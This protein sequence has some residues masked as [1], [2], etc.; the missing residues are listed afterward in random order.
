VLTQDGALSRSLD[1]AAGWRYVTS[2][3]GLHLYVRGDA[4]W[5]RGAAC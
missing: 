3:I 2:D 1:G 5:A 4:D